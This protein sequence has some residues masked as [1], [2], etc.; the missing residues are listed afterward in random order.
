MRKISEEV[1]TVITG[2]REEEYNEIL[3]SCRTPELVYHLSDLRANLIR[4]IEMEENA[5]ILELG[6]ECGA[7]S[8]YLWK[9]AGE[10]VCLEESSEMA[11]LNRIRNKEADNMT[12]L[13]GET[14]KLL[15]ELA[16]ESFDL[17]FMIG[18][19]LELKEELMPKLASLLKK[20]GRLVLAADNKYGLQFFA[21]NQDE[22][23]RGYFPFAAEES[24]SFR[25]LSKKRIE[26]LMELAGL[27]ELLFYYPFPDYRYS[28]VLYSDQYLPRQNE[29]KR[30]WRNMSGQRM[31]LFDEESA[32]R[33]ICRDDLF[34]FFSNSFLV[35]GEKK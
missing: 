21:G 7:I 18:L 27:D 20:G 34:P 6:S 16:P 25:L 26:E 5:R 30:S 2:H 9:K 12:C 31:V 28:T 14:E 10:L 3:G 19:D 35:I 11:V 4:W 1:R 8:S 23:G 33:N 32:F 17:I 24:D 13:C 29:L 15:E 22:D